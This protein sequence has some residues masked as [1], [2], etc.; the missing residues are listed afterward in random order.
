MDLRSPSPK[1]SSLCRLMEAASS[2]VFKTE[3]LS[4]SETDSSPVQTSPPTSPV[5]E[6]QKQQQ[7]QQID[8][9][10]QD[11]ELVELTPI[12]R[13]FL[14]VDDSG[15]Q[16]PTVPDFSRADNQCQTDFPLCR[17]CDDSNPSNFSLSKRMKLGV[18]RAVRSR[19]TRA[20]VMRPKQEQGDNIE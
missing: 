11:L 15:S 13:S 18:T 9:K 8:E 12:E 3:D 1:Y 16:N 14:N 17:R 19:S 4:K 10:P 20:R 2:G 5:A 6:D 7:Q